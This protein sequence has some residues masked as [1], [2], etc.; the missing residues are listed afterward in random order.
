MEAPRTGLDFRLPA[1]RMRDVILAVLKA[2]FSLPDLLG[3]Q[4]NPYRFTP[5]DVAA[6][7]IWIS[8]EEGRVGAGRDGQQNAITVSRS[9][10]T[11]SEAHLHNMAGLTFSNGTQ[12]FSDLATCMLAIRCDAASSDESEILA[13]IAYFVL[14][15]FRR[16]V[17]AEYDLHDLR[18]LH[19]S[20]A[21]RQSEE[22][23]GAFFQT[24]VFLRI[25]MQ[26]HAKM[27]ELSNSLN[28]LDISSHLS[29][30]SLAK[31]VT[32]DASL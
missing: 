10:Y 19:I 15:L 5:G 13:S 24:T 31:I 7:Q 3:G 11:P 16:Q 26:E 23:A 30:G 9:D 18:L 4:G 2:A 32:L 6:S 1:L 21:T 25:E 28:H 8:S 29:D 17:M 22:A 12:N 27:I 20:P 14:K